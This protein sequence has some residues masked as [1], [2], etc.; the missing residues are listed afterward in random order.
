MFMHMS[1]LKRA[2]TV[3]LTP[4]PPSV[5]PS[6]FSPSGKPTQAIYRPATLPCAIY[7]ALKPHEH[8]ILCPET[9]KTHRSQR[10]QSGS[11]CR[12]TRR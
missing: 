1:F 12:R 3:Q 9:V 7:V 5:L 4:Q 11:K 8:S 10:Q 6:L 2:F